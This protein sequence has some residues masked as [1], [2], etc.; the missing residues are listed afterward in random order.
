MTVLTALSAMY[1]PLPAQKWNPFLSWQPIPYSTLASAD[2]DVST[3]IIN[4]TIIHFFIK[5]LTNYVYLYSK[6]NVLLSAKQR[7]FLHIELRVV[8]QYL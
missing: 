6:I 7:P 3:Y 5:L 1:P 4:K 2:D 8:S